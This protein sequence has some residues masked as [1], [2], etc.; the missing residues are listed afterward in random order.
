VI[1]THENPRF[2]PGALK[3]KGEDSDEDSDDQNYMTPS[4]KTKSWFSKLTA[5]IKKSFCLKIDLQ[6]KMYYEH[7][8]N[9]KTLQCQK[10]MM[11]HMGLPVSDV[12]K[13]IITPPK[14]WK[15][16]HKWTSSED[17]ISERTQA[18]GHDE[19]E[20]KDEDKEAGDEYEDYDDDED[21]ENEDDDDED[22][23]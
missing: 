15:S 19:E 1:K 5:R 7:E 18:Q 14:E 17:S 22:D 9:K 3:D 11:V 4:S 20:D 12:S 23:E 6:D 10:A 13:N 8:Q 21:E 2:G 16:K